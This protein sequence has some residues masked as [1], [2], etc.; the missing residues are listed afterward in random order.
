[1]T[2]RSSIEKETTLGSTPVGSVDLMRLIACRIF[3]SAVA[4]SVP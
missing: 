4:R 3:C 1:M 2:G